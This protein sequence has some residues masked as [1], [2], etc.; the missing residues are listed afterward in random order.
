M[1]IATLAH[2]LLCGAD[3]MQWPSLR[4]LGV[5]VISARLVS[6]Y[7]AQ[8]NIFLWHR[9][10]VCGAGWSRVRIV[11]HSWT[12]SSLRYLLFWTRVPELRDYLFCFIHPLP[13]LRSYVGRLVAWIFIVLCRAG[14][15]TC[16]SLPG[17][18]IVG[19][20]ASLSCVGWV[21]CL[22]TPISIFSQQLGLRLTW[23]WWHLVERRGPG[24]LSGIYHQ[25]SVF[26]SKPVASKALSRVN[27]NI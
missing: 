8:G 4:P 11:L 20:W 17:V 23:S 3:S 5:L 22:R 15:F 12:R 13:N 18:L 7:Q 19:L 16:V 27:R 10:V 24:L 26:S 25:S 1:S 21:E 2:L 9:P 6:E 14:K